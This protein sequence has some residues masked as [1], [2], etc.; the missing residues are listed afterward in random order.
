MCFTRT[1]NA[2]PP[3]GM[4][5]HA[6]CVMSVSTYTK[7][8][9]HQ[10]TPNELGTSAERKSKHI[11]TTHATHRY[12]PGGGGAHEWGKEDT[13]QIPRVISRGS[14]SITW[15]FQMTPLWQ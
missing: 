15:D 4:H 5:L 6:N 8:N 1:S 9:P 7:L 13:T 12:N 11:H 10:Q 14:A 2:C 3:K